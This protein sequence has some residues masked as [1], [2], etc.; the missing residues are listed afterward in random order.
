MGID[1]AEIKLDFN[2]LLGYRL[3]AE[4]ANEALLSAKLGD[5]PGSKSLLSAKLGDKVGDKVGTKSA[6]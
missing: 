1:M 2:K 6:V 4:D 3:V 5:K